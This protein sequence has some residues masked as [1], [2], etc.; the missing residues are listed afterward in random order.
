MLA[1]HPF[2]RRR[3]FLLRRAARGNPPRS[4]VGLTKV[5]E[6]I[7]ATFVYPASSPSRHLGEI[8]TRYQELL[9]GSASDS[10]YRSYLTV[11]TAAQ[12]GR[13]RGQNGA[14]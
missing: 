2:G 5:A 12:R 13:T 10:R 1:R 8:V 6:A 11:F 4:K 14:I 7:T 3:H 9:R